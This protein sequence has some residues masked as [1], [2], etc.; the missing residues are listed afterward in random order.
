MSIWGLFADILRDLKM[1]ESR[2]P[3]NQKTTG[4]VLAKYPERH[5]ERQRWYGLER[6]FESGGPRHLARRQERG[7]LTDE[8]MA[9]D[10]RIPMASGQGKLNIFAAFGH[11]IFA[12][13][14]EHVWRV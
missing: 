7:H 2:K 14:R 1:A 4:E 10:A 12:R 6:R 3:P 9:A 5:A 8:V 11:N 13:V